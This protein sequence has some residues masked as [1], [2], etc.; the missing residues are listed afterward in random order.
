MVP[1]CKVTT[2]GVLEIIIDAAFV[3]QGKPITTELQSLVGRL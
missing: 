3:L 2:Y 1:D